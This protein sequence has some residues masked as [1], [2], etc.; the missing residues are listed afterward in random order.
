MYSDGNPLKKTIQI[1]TKKPIGLKK[2]SI[3]SN[4]QKKANKI[5]TFFINSFFIECGFDTYKNALIK[6]VVILFAFFCAFESI[7]YFF[8]PIGFFVLIVCRYS[9]VD[10]YYMTPMLE[11]QQ[12]KGYLFRSSYDIKQKSSWEIGN[13][14][15]V[16]PVTWQQ[17]LAAIW[18][19]TLF[20]FNT[21]FTTWAS[22]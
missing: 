14:E 6:N 10:S 8:K 5:T 21:D 2:Y 12:K 19:I 17:S 18:V 15:V 22:R 1:K 7:E 11:P 16:G 4:T 13:G 3:D 9:V 20:C